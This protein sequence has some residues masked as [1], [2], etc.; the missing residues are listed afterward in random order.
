MRRWL[1]GMTRLYLLWCLLKLVWVRLECSH[2]LERFMKVESLVG[3]TRRYST[4][5]I[6]ERTR[7]GHRAVGGEVEKVNENES[8]GEKV[9][10]LRGS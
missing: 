9:G 3:E 6:A 2:H 7:R 4:E 1:A 10:A 8:G 5:R